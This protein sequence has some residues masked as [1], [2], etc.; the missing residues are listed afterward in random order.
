[1]ENLIKTGSKIG[2]LIIINYLII[3]YK[4]LYGSKAFLKD[5]IKSMQAG[6]QVVI[7]AGGGHTRYYE[8]WRLNF[9]GFVPWSG[10]YYITFLP[11]STG[12]D[13]NN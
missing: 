4:R 2:M 1:M 3:L 12:L 7:D 9:K 13:P 10:P 11:G 5:L 6:Y 8:Y